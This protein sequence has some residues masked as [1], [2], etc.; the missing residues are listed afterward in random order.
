MDG[1]NFY[2]A[3]GEKA[4]RGSTGCGCPTRGEEV[5]VYGKYEQ[6]NTVERKWRLSAIRSVSE[7]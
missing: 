4:V 6:W 2:D 1:I 5:D 7:S 3:D